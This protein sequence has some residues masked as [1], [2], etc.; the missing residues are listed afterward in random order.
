MGEFTINY[1]YEN[2]RIVTIIGKLSINGSVQFLG[3]PDFVRGSGL[4]FIK[5]LQ[6]PT[7]P[8]GW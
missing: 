8:T 5:N 7:D 2:G 3:I 4:S 6:S 1:L